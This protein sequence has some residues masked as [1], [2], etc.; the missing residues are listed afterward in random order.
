MPD[1]DEGGVPLQPLHERW[2]QAGV[3]WDANLAQVTGNRPG[4]FVPLNEGTTRH[5]R[6]ELLSKNGG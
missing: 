6:V 3:A 4:G 2:G 5:Q 1:A